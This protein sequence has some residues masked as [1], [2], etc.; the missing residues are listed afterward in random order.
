MKKTNKSEIAEVLYEN[1]KILNNL[2]K[3]ISK[4]SETEAKSDIVQ[5][6]VLAMCEIANTLSKIKK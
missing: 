4:Y 2:N 5:K 3:E 1:F 6:N